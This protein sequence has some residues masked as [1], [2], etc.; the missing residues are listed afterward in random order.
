MKLAEKSAIW[1]YQNEMHL[2]LEF[3]ESRLIP[4]CD[5]NQ[6]YMAGWRIII[7]RAHN[8][9]NI[10][11]LLCLYVNALFSSGQIRYES[12]RWSSASLLP[13]FSGTPGAFV[14]PSPRQMPGTSP[15]PWDSDQPAATTRHVVGPLASSTHEAPSLRESGE[16]DQR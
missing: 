13:L 16:Q 12:T 10:F 1:K 15:S 2:I 8:L 6:R 14:W 5:S 7:L 3:K 11:F 4:N 9:I